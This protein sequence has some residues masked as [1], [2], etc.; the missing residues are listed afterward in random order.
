M[1]QISNGDFLGKYFDRVF[2]MP[3]LLEEEVVRLLDREVES[4]V[5]GL[6]VPDSIKSEALKEY[7]HQSHEIDPLIRINITTFRSLKH[8]SK[9]FAATLVRLQ[10][11]V[12]LAD[13][14]VMAILETCD[15]ALREIIFRHRRIL[16]LTTTFDLFR[17]VWGDAQDQERGRFLSILT[18][19]Q[20]PFVTYLFPHIGVSSEKE[21]SFHD[22]YV[23]R[24]R[25]A[26]ERFFDRYFRE[27]PMELAAQKSFQDEVK[28]KAAAD[29]PIAELAAL[30]AQLLN[31]ERSPY[32][33]LAVDWLKRTMRTGL[34]VDAAA[35]LLRA[36]AIAA[37]KLPTSGFLETERQSAAY[38]IF[39]FLN[40]HPGYDAEGK[41]L[42][43]DIVEDPTTS[44]TFVGI[45]VHYAC[46]PETWP[47]PT[48]TPPPK[49]E[50][51]SWFLA[52]ID[53]KLKKQADILAAD[54][55]DDLQSLVFRWAETL[56]VKPQSDE[57]L[58]LREVLRKRLTGQESAFRSFVSRVPL[59][60]VDGINART[61]DALFGQ[62][63]FATILESLQ[64]S[65]RHYQ[66]WLKG[67]ATSDQREAG[68]EPDQAAP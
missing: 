31:S 25:I 27:L 55:S 12:S 51:A 23:V 5:R 53:G 28:S 35:R 11:D 36:L 10:C 15:P 16:T 61:I 46:Y 8:F 42:Y 9:L 65:D 50:I 4:H 63:N 2:F 39:D 48:H 34:E 21:R 7:R 47:A 1:D 67:Y 32:R 64:L 41:G 40:A 60:D 56:K 24:Q 22:D 45:I 57:R 38:A 37:H 6:P 30:T 20:K 14:V 49:E 3:Q 54:F 66:D 68:G 26:D 17:E 59:M 19:N 58:N 33:N 43:R 62:A 18:D 52:R 13:M 44:D 29:I